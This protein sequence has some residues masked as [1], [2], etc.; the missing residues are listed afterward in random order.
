MVRRALLRTIHRLVVSR[1][2]WST[3]RAVVSRTNAFRAKVLVA[4]VGAALLAAILPET[5]FEVVWAAGNYPA[6][7]AS[8]AP[9][10]YWR[11]DETSG[12]SAADSSSAHANPLTYQGGVTLVI[13]PGAING[14]ADPA[15]ALNGSNGT[16]T[17]TNATTT[18]TTNWTLEAWLNPSTLPQAGVVAYDGQL[19]TNGYGFA[20]GATNGSSLSSGSH[21]IGILGSVTMFDSGFNF[22]A[23]NTWYHVVMTRD[24]TKATLYAN[25]VAQATTSTQTPVAPGARFSLGSGF[26]ST[27]VQMNPFAGSIDE[28]ASYNALLSPGRILAHYTEGASAQSAFGSWTTASP[29]N[30]PSARFEPAMGWDAAHNKVVLFGGKS[31]TGTA[32]QETWTW[33]GTTWTRL[34]PSTQPSARWGAQLVYDTALGKMV[35]FGGRTSSAAQQDTWTWNGTTWAQVTTSTK[36]AARLEYGLAYDAAHSVVVM[37]GGTTGSAALQDT[38]T[39]QGTNWTLKS[40]SLKPSIRSQV[41][42]TYNTATSN[43]V[44]FG[45]VNGTT[46]SAETWTWDGTNWTPKA[47]AGA[48]SARSNSGLAYN[49]MTST[50]VLIGGVNGSSYFGDTWTWDGTT[51]TQQLPA[52]S[53]TVR[54]GAGFAINGVNGSD[55]LFGGLSGTT[56]LNDSKAW[57]NPPGAP[58][59]VAATAGNGQATVTWTAPTSGGSAITGYMVTPYAGSQAG[60]TSQVGASPATI[61]GLTNGT[62]YTFKVYAKNVIGNGSFAT[63]NAVTPASTPG[64]PTNVVAAPGSASASGSWTA[65][66]SGGSPITSYTV[67]PFINGTQGTPQNPAGG[68]TSVTFSSLTNGNTLYF[69]IYATNSVGNGPTATSNTIIVGSPTAPGNVQAT[70]GV[71][72]AV[73]TWTPSS[74]NAAAITGYTVV[75]YIGV[76]ATTRVNVGPSATQVTVYGL[77]GQTAYT[78]QVTAANSFGISPAGVSAGVT[79]TGAGSTYES[80]IA[81]D[82]PSAYWR[83]DD[84]S[85]SVAT[86]TT[87]HVDGTYN[88]SVSLS[89]S[90]LIP[91]DPDT[92]L[93]LDGN[94]AYVSTPTITALQGGNTRSVEIWLSTSSTNG[95]VFFD[96]G[97]TGVTGQLFEIG[98]TSQGGVGNNPPANTPGLYVAF[99]NSDAYLPG[100]NLGDGRTHHIVVTLSGTTL[101]VYVDGQTPSAY[102]YNGTWNT[103]LFG[104]P[105]TLPTTPATPSNPVWVG[106]GRQSLWSGSSYFSGRIDEVAIY[107]TVLTLTQVQNHESA[108]QVILSA[109]VIGT[110]TAGS[111]QATVNWS[112]AS[113]TAAFAGFNVTAYQGAT[114][115]VSKAVAATATSAT[116]TGL[117]GSAPYTIRVSLSNAFSSVSTTSSAVTPTGTLSTYASTVETS[118]PQ[119]I[120]YYRLS[121]TVATVAADSSGYGQAGTYVGTPTMGVAGALANDPDVAVTFTSGYVSYS[122]TNIPI[123][124]SGRSVEL[125]L[126][127]TSTAGNQQLMGWGTGDPRADF[128]IRFDGGTQIR[129]NTWA[130][131]PVINLPYSL[132]NGQW[133][134]V[135]LTFDGTNLVVYVDGNPAGTNP[136]GALATNRTSVSIGS[137]FQGTLDEVAVYSGALSSTQ[138]NTHFLASGNSQPAAPATVTATAGANSAAVTWTASPTNPYPVQGYMVT[139]YS[140]TQALNGLATGASATSATISGLPSG[141]AYTFKVA[142]I[143]NFGFGGATA[144]AA[145]TPTGTAATYASNVIGTG[146]AG[147][148][149]VDYWRLGDTSLSPYAADSSGNGGWAVYNAGTSIGTT[150][151]LPNDPDTSIAGSFTY[152][153]G[154]GLPTGNASR[155]VE[156]WLKTTST[157]FQSLVQ[158]GDNNSGATNF[159]V[160]VVG[161]QI[162]INVNNQTNPGFSSPYTLANGQWHY[163]VVTFNGSAMTVYVDGSSIGPPW[164][165]GLSTDPTK[166]LVGNGFT[167]NL[168]D[169]A[170]YNRVL[171]ASEVLAHFLASGNSQPPAPDS[172]GVTPANNQATISWG[173]NVTPPGLTGYLVSAYTGSSEA[174]SVGVSPT[175]SSV[176]MTGLQGGVSYT[177]RVA[178]VNNFG[179]GLTITSSPATPTGSSTTFPS[180][181]LG[182]IPVAYYRL[183]DSS[184]FAA[185]SSGYNLIGS[186][187]G[188]YTLGVQGALTGDT[189]TAMSGGGVQVNQTQSFPSGAAVRTLETWFKT[190]SSSTQN[191]AAYG[192]NNWFGTN[193]IW[194][195]LSGGTQLNLAT[196]T[197]SWAFTAPYSMT[198]GQ[199]HMADVMY[200][201]TNL[202]MYL[203]GNS[204]GSQAVGGLSTTA[205]THFVVGP[206]SGSLDE[207]SV[208]GRVLTA[209]DVSNH[210]QAAGAGVPNAPTNVSAVA[211]ANSAVVRWTP[212]A[213]RGGPVTSFTITPKLDTGASLAPM[214]VTA[215]T[216]SANIPNLPGGASISFAV[217]ANNIYG[218]GPASTSPAV[219]IQGAQAAAGMDRFLAIA[220]GGNPSR[221]IYYEGWTSNAAI[222]ASQV[223]Q[224][225]IEGWI[226]A[227]QYKGTET[228]NMAWGLLNTVTVTNP[229]NLHVTIPASDLP[230]AGINFNIGELHGLNQCCDVSFVWPH[231]GDVGFGTS[232]KYTPTIPTNGFDLGSL[233]G[234][235]APVYIALDY[236]GTNVRG[237]ANGNLIFTQ[238]DSAAIPGDSWPGFMDQTELA[239]GAFDGFRV[240]NVARYTG[241]SFS[242]PTADT[243]ADANTLVD[244]NF[245][246]YPVGKQESELI[247]PFNPWGATTWGNWPD[248]SSHNNSASFVALSNPWSIGWF[249]NSALL[250]Q[251]FE[252]TTGIAPGELADE[253]NGVNTGSGNFCHRSTDLSI[254]GRGPSLSLTRTYNSFAA[255]NLGT[256]GYGWSNSYG[257]RLVVDGGGNVTLY[258]PLGGNAFFPNQNGSF[259]TASYVSTALS[260]SGG[261]YTLA[262]KR[263]G[264]LVFNSN[265]QLIQEIDRNG[266]V[267]SLAYSGSNLITVTEPAGRQLT[268]TYGSNGLVSAVTD[269]TRTSIYGYDTNLNLNSVTNP[270]GG[271]TTFTYDSSHRMLTDKGPVCNLTTGCNG[272]VNVYDANGRVSQQTDPGGSPITY[273]YTSSWPLFTTTVTD[274]YGHQNKY[275]Y[276]LGLPLDVIQAA[277]TSLAATTK[278]TYDPASLGVASVTNPNSETSTATYDAKTNPLTSTDAL[279]NRTTNTYNSWGQPLTVQDPLGVITTNSY[280]A[281]GNLLSTSSPL[282]GSASNLVYT[283]TY[284]DPSHPGDVTAQ[285]D[286][287]NHTWAYVYDSYG[288]RT[289]STD[290]LGNTTTFAFDSLGRVTSI[291]SPLGN[292]VGGNPATYTTTYTYNAA[293]E[294]LTIT[295]PLGHQVVKQYDVA[296]H[297]VQSTDPNGSVTTFSYDLDG[298]PTASTAAYGTPQATTSRTNYNA[299]GNVLSQIDGLNHTLVSYTY[300]ALNREA[301]STDG[302]TRTTTY[303]YDKANRLIGT[304]NPLN[305]TSSYS[306]DSGGRLTGVSYSDGL[307]PSVSYSYDAEGHLLTMIDGTGTTTNVWDSLH[308]LTQQTDG[309]GHAVAYSYDLASRL[310]SIA[311]PGG[312]CTASPMTLCVTRQYDN[313][314][315]LSSVQDWLSNQTTFGYDANSNLTGITYANGVVA[316]NTYNSADQ[317]VNISDV[318]GANT[319]LSF[320]YGRDSNA[321]LTS[322]N[323][324][325][326]AYNSLNQLTTGAGVGYLYDAAGRLTQTVSGSTTTNDNY[327]NSDELI[328]TA[329]V[330]GTT[331]N[332]IYD[333]A[334]RRINAGSTSLTWN[335][336]D[337]LLTYGSSNSYT[338]NGAGLRVSKTLAGQSEAFVWDTA[339]GLPL[340]LGDGSTLYITGP[341][342]LPLEQV[343][344]GAVYYY[345]HDQL[346]STRALTDSTGAVAA[347][348]NYD[349]YGNI[350]SQT[351]S[352]N[353]PF[354][355]TGQYRDSE[356]G[357]YHLRARYYDPA[358]GQFI[359]RDPKLNSTWAPYGYVADNPLNMTD[360]SGLDPISDGIN[361]LYQQGVNAYNAV[362]NYVGEMY[363]NFAAQISVVCPPAG[364]FLYGLAAGYNL[365]VTESNDPWFLLGEAVGIGLNV[366]LLLTGPEDPFADASAVR[367]ASKAPK[368]AEL[369]AKGGEGVSLVLKYK[370]G[371]SAEQIAAA[372][373]K[374][375]ALNQAAMRGELSVAKV[376]RSGSSAASMWRSAGR[377]IPSGSDIDHTIDLQLNGPN[378]LRNMS[379]LDRSVNRSLGAQIA[380]QLRGVA[381]GTRINSV[382]IF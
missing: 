192:D 263:G 1:S 67:I 335:Q 94:S 125:W 225:T 46:Y 195:I 343:T 333:A 174:Q 4:L 244:Y 109:P 346:G 275:E 99:G 47:P 319:I 79:P 295:D 215:S 137:N 36:P 363:Y 254:P 43:T 157:S 344:G 271:V 305:Q 280:D 118:T 31:S 260:F 153:T 175:S 158:W 312:S 87:G 315:R 317:L 147:N 235:N 119:P 283:Y 199:W 138:V 230:K 88:G 331:T 205:G 208:Y 347:S 337:H 258:D 9:I 285:T 18:G 45:G 227:V 292:V 139:A 182:S 78:F 183:G 223:T 249:A 61:T 152:G 54:A 209:S 26:T 146:P 123:G 52:S 229:G 73:L 267:T 108:A 270:L 274:P 30:P 190:T 55:A 10:G 352:V 74:Q 103:T 16:V 252:L 237:Y 95:Q 287:T 124:N 362:T 360:A 332:Y 132:A 338:Y 276:A 167:G 156:V 24:T 85:G 179:Q 340:L 251:P 214:S 377:E 121:D 77:Q 122:G 172:V 345:Q 211:G 193:F 289:S 189:D 170:V 97:T 86:D 29:S 196:T 365:D 239:Q 33:D 165:I 342:G 296:G 367:L 148:G 330:G 14:D 62:T 185:D 246:N 166:L 257:A 105:F 322:E 113:N 186:Y 250:F 206:L 63:S 341:G 161:D 178:A 72:Q 291:V 357:M 127:T 281:N 160:Q 65:P 68:A 198:D 11:L 128:D 134:Q 272:L 324:A 34:T 355:F 286:P 37:F 194:Q 140:G 48:P 131:N 64:V 308:R 234:G 372:E 314:G 273:T 213:P 282:V 151:A 382:A 50:V 294:P 336:Q 297:V 142:G 98:L 212:P 364:S 266:Y 150:S 220:T 265:G 81:T 115:T 204:L 51:W 309:A 353:N 238:A 129:I 290:P 25:A 301:T 3:K 173:W 354:L 243:T 256:F 39:F 284:G 217:A 44:L 318:K 102:I 368:A 84:P 381:P 210:W 373:T 380:N 325:T 313:I 20:V 187:T 378:I 371:W 366:A 114:A 70:A 93:G 264:K 348:Y 327:D 168:D 188:T 177:F 203:D 60:T 232:G 207:V 321:Q 259:A 349:A 169:V 126:K 255:T 145:V 136:V 320:A 303:T 111:N 112:D 49:P 13:Q 27:S 35:L 92:A 361:W 176:V 164:N 135:V 326:Y 224:W 306:Y 6:V 180:S 201:G 59:A 311:Y 242:V 339:D 28:A 334:G 351:G 32:I 38:Y 233:L 307:T 184:G 104:Q 228:G 106:H 171:S 83:L 299:G 130:S 253:C 2:T 120:F 200:D 268:F 40:P 278:Y 302:M 82:G 91:S 89:Q 141:V 374:V 323:S 42:M 96:S 231:N 181:V 279:G 221:G 8:D 107:P 197:T 100:L 288:D 219:S 350:A 155:S 117:M 356:T 76:Q 236:D 298:R 149:P 7:A 329:V 241:S 222:P 240:S 277:D 359:S 163:L 218:T 21:L 245:D 12:T 23:P 202:S 80:T 375:A 110:V 261:N 379:P 41:A 293:R 101:K 17:A 376:E 116:L 262:D 57:A 22:S 310:T 144:S 300:D 216:T 191:L 162:V 56:Y 248:S 90:G 5:Q 316:T 71:N 247:T 133:H 143:N 66:S 369:A 358:T 328:S 159:N 58:T 53:P 304:V 75:G 15:V 19:G 226:W 269:G 69:T 370:E 154:I